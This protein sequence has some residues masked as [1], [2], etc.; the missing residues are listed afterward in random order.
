MGKGSRSKKAQIFRYLTWESLKSLPFDVKHLFPVACL[1][2]LADS[3]LTTA[4]VQKVKYTEI[5]WVAYMQEVEGFLN[6]T[7]DYSQLKDQGTNIRLAQYIFVIFYILT[8]A[9]VFRLY[10]RSKKVPPYMLV[11]MCT[12]SYRIHSIFVLRLF[13]DP[14]AVLLLYIALNMFL[15]GRWSMGSVVYSLAVSVKMNILLYSPALL[16]AYLTSLGPASTLA[17]LMICAGV[18]LTLGAPFLLENPTAYL[19]GSFDIGRVF[20]HEWT[21]NWRFL[22]ED[23]FT[24]RIFHVGLLLAQIAVLYLFYGSSTTYLKSYARLKA[25]ETDVKPQLKKERVNMGTSSQLFLL[26]FFLSNF[27]GVVFSRSLHYQ[28]YVWYYHTLPYLLWCTRL[29]T[30]WRLLLL[31]CIE[32]SWNTFPSTYFSSGLLHFSHIM[33]LF[34]LYQAIVVTKER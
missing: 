21:V 13:N 1:C 18:Q 24:N 22:P 3:L 30:K 7:L 11:L 2:L 34:S 26:P 16:L 31:G 19:K 25:L 28:F 9:S 10:L 5:D 27:I 20:L 6:G 8:V 15:D 14:L 12:T 17:Q 4:V 32:L 33:I 29:S 23:I